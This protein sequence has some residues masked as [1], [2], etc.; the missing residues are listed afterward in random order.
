[1]AVYAAQS[2]ML[3]PTIISPPHFKAVSE[4][5]KDTRLFY[6]GLSFGG[7]QHTLLTLTLLGVKSK[8]PSWIALYGAQVIFSVIIPCWVIH[9]YSAN[10]AELEQIDFVSARYVYNYLNPHDQIG[11][12][13]D[14]QEREHSNPFFASYIQ[15]RTAPRIDQNQEAVTICQAYNALLEKNCAI[16]TFARGYLAGT[17]VGQAPAAFLLS[18]CLMKGCP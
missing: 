3:L 1:M 18:M 15:L 13:Q 6:E 11:L 12:D 2:G 17:L 5:E 8:N 7:V 14:W 9:H 16:R 10:I 4:V